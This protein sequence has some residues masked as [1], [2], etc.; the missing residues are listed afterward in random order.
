[1]LYFI[2]QTKGVNKMAEYISRNEYIARNKEADDIKLTDTNCTLLS[3]VVLSRLRRM[4]DK[5]RK[6][7][8]EEFK[9]PLEEA[10]SIWKRE[11]FNPYVHGWRGLE[12]R[13]CFVCIG[14]FAEY[15]RNKRS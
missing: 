13:K 11:N 2:Y 8:E 10:I 5:D 1:M 4:E 9:M 7:F 12:W 3:H 15:M 14:D 6:T